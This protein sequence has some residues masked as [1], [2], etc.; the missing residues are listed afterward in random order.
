MVQLN[1]ELITCKTNQQ[2][3]FFEIHDGQSDSPCLYVE[4]V[5]QTNSNWMKTILPKYV[6]CI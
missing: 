6:L 4:M 3:A 5:I 2:S 1:V